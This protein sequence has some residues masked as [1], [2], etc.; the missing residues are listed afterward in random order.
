MTSNGRVPRPA[1]ER[2]HPKKGQQ[3]ESHTCKCGE[4][5]GGGGGEGTWDGM[6]L[7]RDQSMPIQAHC[8]VPHMIYLSN[9]R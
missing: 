4:R 2:Q 1:V 7:G 8:T 9:I 6:L 5:E 3:G